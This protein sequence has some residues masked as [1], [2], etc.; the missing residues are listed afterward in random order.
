MNNNNNATLL[1]EVAKDSLSFM[2]A[3]CDAVG[4]IGSTDSETI[5]CNANNCGKVVHK[6]CHNCLL[7]CHCVEPLIDPLTSN[8]LFACSKTCY[9]RINKTI[10]QQPSTQIPWDK[11]GR[12]GPDDPKHYL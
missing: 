4:C 11:D 10:I 1:Q 5:L 6:E 3:K 8:A 2:P 7:N 12:N 9:N